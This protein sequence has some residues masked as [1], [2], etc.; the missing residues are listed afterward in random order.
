MA[1]KVKNFT[2]PEEILKKLNDYSKKSLIPQ[3]RL[4]TKLLKDFFI[5]E[6][7]K[8]VKK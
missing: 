8:W 1:T 2:I 4:V 5:N 6:E 3:S 7:E